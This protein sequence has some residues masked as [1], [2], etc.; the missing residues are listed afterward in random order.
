MPLAAL[1]E[2]VVIS[3]GRRCRVTR[4]TRARDAVMNG[5][6]VAPQEVQRR[7]SSTLTAKS[8]A[9]SVATLTD[10]ADELAASALRLES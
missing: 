8:D 2:A 1:G 10:D 5:D 3:S 4:I 9:Q 7:L 6:F